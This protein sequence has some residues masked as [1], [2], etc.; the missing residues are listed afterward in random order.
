MKN[1]NFKSKR[2]IGSLLTVVFIGL[3]VMNPETAA[4]LG[5]GVACQFVACEA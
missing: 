3:G 1:I 2:L 4:Q 5:T